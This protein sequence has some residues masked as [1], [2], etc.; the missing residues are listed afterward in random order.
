M[1]RYCQASGGWYTFSKILNFAWKCKCFHW[2][3]TLSDVFLEWQAHLVDSKENICQTLNPE[4][5]LVRF[6]S[7][8]QSYLT[9]CD[10]MDCSTPGFPVHH[11]LLELTQTHVHRVSDAIRPSHSL[12]S[13]F[14]P[15]FNLSQHQGIFQWVSSSHQVAKVLELQLQHQFFQWIFRTDFLEDWLVC[16]PCSPRDSQESS[17]ASQFKSIDSSLL[18]FLYSPTLTSIHDYWK[19]IA[20][21]RWT[22]VG[23]VMFLLFIMLSRLFIAFLPK[24]KHLW[25]LLFLS[26]KNAV[27]KDVCSWTRWSNRNWIYPTTW[28]LKW[29]TDWNRSMKDGKQM[30]H[31]CNCSS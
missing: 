28:F 6:S 17:P 12:S 26:G 3:Q 30:M 8:A 7:I 4:E 18:S 24:S 10:P 13:L 15:A 9:L 2:Q 23:K 22:F 19:T 25:P 14:P 11:Q 1:V 29:A 20:L 27:P 21:T 31:L 5:L 16:S